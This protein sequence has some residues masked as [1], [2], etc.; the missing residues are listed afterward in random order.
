[1]SPPLWFLEQLVSNK[2]CLL[3]LEGFYNEKQPTVFSLLCHFVFKLNTAEK[4]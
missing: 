1:M 4:L 2:Y 3:E